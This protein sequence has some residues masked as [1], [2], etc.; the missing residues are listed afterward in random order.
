PPARSCMPVRT[1]R[2]MSADPFFELAIPLKEIE[3]T[4]AKLKVLQPTEERS[5]AELEVPSIVWTGPTQ[6][7]LELVGP[8]TEARAEFRLATLITVVG[9]L[10]GRRCWVSQPHPTY[11]NFYTLLVGTTGDTRKTTAYRFGVN[12][13]RNVAEQLKAKVKPLFGLA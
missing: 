13:L 12:L 8:C 9:S 6:R 4:R 11:P 1:E 7:Y 2:G 5:A 3:A 10:L